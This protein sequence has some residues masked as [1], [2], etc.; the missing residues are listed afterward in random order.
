MIAS[1]DHLVLTTRDLDKCVAFYSEILEMKLE[2]F[3]DNRLAL[4]FGHQKI[5]LHEFGREF[6]PKAYTPMPGSLDLCFLINR[7]LKEVMAKLEACGVPVIEGPV[8][9]TGASSAILS[10][11]VR[12]PDGNLIELAQAEG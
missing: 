11:Y 4:H 5:N 7:S 3:G 1:L 10:V 2:R 12:D 6:E 8:R 9:R